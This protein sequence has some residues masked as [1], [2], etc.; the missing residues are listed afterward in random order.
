MDGS[1][2]QRKNVIVSGVGLKK[3][4]RKL[5]PISGENAAG[6]PTAYGNVDE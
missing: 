6:V 3:T 1:R 4:R 5:P 2:A